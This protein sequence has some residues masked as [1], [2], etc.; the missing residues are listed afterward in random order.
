MNFGVEINRTR[1]FCEM[2]VA[3]KVVVAVS[4]LAR[5]TAAEE[6][7]IDREK[8]ECVGEP[9][10][11]DAEVEDTPHRWAHYLALSTNEPEI[12]HSKVS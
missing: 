9:D 11:G 12:S 5:N 6:K 3:I 10:R 1:D 8:Y 4:D 2:P 7:R